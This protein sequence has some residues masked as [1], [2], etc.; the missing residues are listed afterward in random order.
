MTAGCPIIASVNQSSE[1]TRIIKQSGAGLVVIP[2]EPVSPLSAIT[3][4]QNDSHRLTGMSEAG[5]R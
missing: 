5:R 4:L 1:L 2:E 3:S